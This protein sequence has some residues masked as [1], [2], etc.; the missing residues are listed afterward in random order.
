[1]A[2]REHSNSRSDTEQG[3]RKPKPPKRAGKL[4]ILLVSSEMWFSPTISGISVSLIAYS[5]FLICFAMFGVVLL[6]NDHL[7]DVP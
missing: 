1:M 3:S 5:S 2:D 4:K 7:F 6:T